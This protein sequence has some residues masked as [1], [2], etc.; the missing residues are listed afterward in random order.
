MLINTIMSSVED[1]KGGRLFEGWT[2]PEHVL[3]AECA[4]YNFVSLFYAIYLKT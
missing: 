1:E 4:D 3:P 2:G